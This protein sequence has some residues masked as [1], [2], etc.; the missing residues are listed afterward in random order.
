MKFAAI[1]IRINLGCVECT[2]EWTQNR[3]LRY[4]IYYIMKTG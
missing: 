2:K 4:V 3:P 1:N